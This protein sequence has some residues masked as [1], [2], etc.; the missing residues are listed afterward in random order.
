M[1]GFA[2]DPACVAVAVGTELT[3]VG[4]FAQ[5]PLKPGRVDGDA[6]VVADNNPIRP[7]ST[8]SQAGFVFTQPGSYGFYCE[9]HVHERMLGAV[10]VGPASTS[11]PGEAPAAAVV[12]I[13]PDS[14]TAVAGLTAAAP[15]TPARAWEDRLLG[16]DKAT[17][18][19]NG[20][21][22]RNAFRGTGWETE[23]PFPEVPSALME[24]WEVT[25]YQPDAPPTENHISAA[26]SL[27]EAAYQAAAAN[28]WFDFEVGSRDG[29]RRPA[30]DPTHFSNIDFILDDGWL[31]P[32]RPEFLMYY[33]TA[34]G[35]K[36]AGMMF[37]A[38]SPDEQGPQVSGQL[39]LWHYHLWSEPTCLL[40]G[41]LVT[42]GA[43]CIAPNEVTAQISPEMLHVWLVDHPGG[44][45]A[46]A[47]EMEPDLLNALLA[48]RFPD[49]GW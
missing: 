49:R 39:T 31:D 20:R 12:S 38:R 25:R 1:F 46:T 10:F 18:P 32:N 22:M 16:P 48:R 5:H 36:L 19:P 23:R 35:P 8:G 43:P 45:F 47:M 13:A 29:F 24:V 33:Q 27:V 34:T 26:R 21:L 44:A 30:G 42:T 28:R 11:A 2:F 6:V 9:A 14:E 17:L 37:L 15:G 4:N 40:H 7:T 41:L 3:F